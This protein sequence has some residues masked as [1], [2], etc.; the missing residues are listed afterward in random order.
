MTISGDAEAP[1]FRT[2]LANALSNGP[3]VLTLTT[4]SAAPVE[5]EALDVFRPPLGRE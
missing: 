1:I 3:H 4:T 5:I 2:R